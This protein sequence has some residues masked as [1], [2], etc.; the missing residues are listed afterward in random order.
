MR[1]FQSVL[2]TLLAVVALPSAT[3][4]AGAYAYT[5]QVPITASN[6]PAGAVLY[7]ICVGYPNGAAATGASS[8][9]LTPTNGSYSGTVSIPVSSAAPFTSYL[10]QAQVMLGG[11]VANLQNTA[12][13][14]PVAVPGWNG[15]MVIKGSP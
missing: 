3:L 2:L 12:S 15:T 10:C 5:F 6:L 7:V 9:P 4:A 8:S 11:A 14:N 13:L 1:F